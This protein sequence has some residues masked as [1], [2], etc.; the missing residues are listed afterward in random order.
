MGKVLLGVVLLI[1]GLVTLFDADVPVIWT[2]GIIVGILLIVRGMVEQ[3]QKDKIEE[4]LSALAKKQEDILVRLQ[5]GQAI[6]TIADEYHQTDDIPPIRTIQVVAHL[7]KNCAESGDRELAGVAT[8]VA[9]RQIVDSNVEPTEVIESFS[10]V[11][12]VYFV[13]EPVTMYSEDPKSKQGAEGTAILSKGFLFFFSEKPNPLNSPAVDRALG[14]LGDV[15]PGISIT[16]TGYALVS[17]LSKELAEYFN[18]SRK[19]KLKVRFDYPESVALP[20]VAITDMRLA[21]RSGMVFESRYLQLSGSSANESWTYWLHSGA[22]DE[23]KWA[24]SWMERLQLACIA[25]GNL[26]SGGSATEQ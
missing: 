26:M 21:A 14:K 23:D 7:I 20:L 18:A 2:G 12:Q 3:S 15:V 1:A 10:F 22:M 6:D 4:G 11:D 25:E 13:D 19:A 17:G 8:L 9:S 5:K 16:S 24:I